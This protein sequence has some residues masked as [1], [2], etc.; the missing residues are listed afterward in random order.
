LTYRVALHAIYRWAA[1]ISNVCLYSSRV[2]IARSFV[3]Y[4]LAAAAIINSGVR[5][6]RFFK[7]IYWKFYV[8]LVYEHESA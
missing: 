5:G 1:F 2:T 6:N 8:R 4:R 3:Y 7:R